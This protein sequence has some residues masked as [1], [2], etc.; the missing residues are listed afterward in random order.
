MGDGYLNAYQPGVVERRST[1]VSLDAT[2]SVPART[3]RRT[4]LTRDVSRIDPIHV[5][6]TYYAPGVGLVAQQTVAASTSELF[7]V[8]MRPERLPAPG[9]SLLDIPD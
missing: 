4:V 1:V 7:L 8:R 2:A 9:L 6:R 5:D 3:Y